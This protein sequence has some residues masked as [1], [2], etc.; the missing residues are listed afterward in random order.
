MPT[1]IE[2]IDDLKNKVNT[3]D[4]QV[5]SAQSQETVEEPQAVD[6]LLAILQPDNRAKIVTLLDEV[7]SEKGLGLY[8]TMLGF[9]DLFS[10]TFIA[11]MNENVPDEYK[12]QSN[13]RVNDVRDRI[14]NSLNTRESNVVG[15]DVIALL[16]IV[17]EGVILS[18]QRDAKMLE[19]AQAA[20]NTSK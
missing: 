18:V 5:E 4:T 15:E 9:T 11:V 7:L 12:E 17:A 13:S 1:K 19:Q 6:G 8:E 2:N 14:I 20:Q 10:A 3:D 16:S